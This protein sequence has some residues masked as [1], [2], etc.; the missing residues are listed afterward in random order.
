MLRFDFYQKMI[1]FRKRTIH[2]VFHW[3]KKSPTTAGQAFRCHYRC[4]SGYLLRQI[5]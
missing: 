2:C 3:Q 1:S 5:P 4:I